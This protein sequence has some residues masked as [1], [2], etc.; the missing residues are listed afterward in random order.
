MSNNFQKGN[1]TTF[2]N[3][4]GLYQKDN[5][6]VAH[7]TDVVLSFPF[8]DTVLEAGM[9]KEDAGREERFLHLEVDGRDIDVLFE[10]KVLT[11]YQYVT[12]NTGNQST[13]QPIII[14]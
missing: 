3:R 2:S 11:N 13:N 4:T 9:T 6:F 8:K 5:G 14:A 7:N 10:P 12:R 1:Y